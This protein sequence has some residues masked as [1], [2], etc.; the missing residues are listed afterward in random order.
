MAKVTGYE[1]SY[2]ET[3]HNIHFTLTVENHAD[4]DIELPPEKA[5]FIHEMLEEHETDWDSGRLIVTK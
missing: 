4:V 3:D 5:L 2:W 1:Y